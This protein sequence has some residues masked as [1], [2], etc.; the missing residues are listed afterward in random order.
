MMVMTMK[1]LCAA[2]LLL[3]TAAAP[4][5][6]QSRDIG[7][8]LADAPPGSLRLFVSGALREPILAVKDKL[9]QATSRKLYAE[10]SESRNLQREI[11]AGQPFEAA[12]LTTPVIKDLAA[13]GKIVSGS[14]MVIAEVRVGVSVRG[15]APKLDI[16]TAEGLK[17]AITGA[18]SIRRYYGVAASTPTLEKLFMGLDLEAATKDRMVHLGNGEIPPEAPLAAGQYEMIIN[19]ISAIKPMPGWRYLGPI[20][21]QF[22][23]PVVH[24]AG[25]GADGDRAAGEKVMQILKGPEFAAALKVSGVTGQ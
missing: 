18:H 8:K 13:K 12:L 5:A 1:Q 15:D 23:I 20:P 22:Q 16:A 19:L 3:C 24:A 14:D 9:E 10:V 25:I 21:E 4:A 7:G 6:A 17:A 2:L 11:E